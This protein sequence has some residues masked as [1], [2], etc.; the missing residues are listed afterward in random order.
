MA[1][2]LPSGGVASLCGLERLGADPELLAVVGSWRDTLAHE[3]VLRPL[4]ERHP[5]ATT[6]VGFA[7]PIH[8]S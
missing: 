8:R 6:S 7:L 2:P 5:G 1:G 4:R 3:N